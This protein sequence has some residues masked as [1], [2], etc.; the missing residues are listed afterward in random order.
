M[1]V[2]VEKTVISNDGEE[3]MMSEFEGT[4]EEVESYIEGELDEFIISYEKDNLGIQPSITMYHDSEDRQYTMVGT[5][6]KIKF[7][8]KW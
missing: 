4:S 5:N 6:N 2:T 3:N 7:S 8:L 1:K